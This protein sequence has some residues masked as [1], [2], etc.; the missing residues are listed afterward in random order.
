MDKVKD[1]KTMGQKSVYL[2]SVNVADLP[3]EVR[4]QSEDYDSL[5]AVH[6]F[7]GEQVAL[8]ADASVASHLAEMNDLELVN[9]H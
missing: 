8:V 7:E 4:A 6:N 3:D 9:V 2:K 1:L 5:V